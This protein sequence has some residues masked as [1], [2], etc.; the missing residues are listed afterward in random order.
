MAHGAGSWAAALAEFGSASVHVAGQGLHVAAYLW[1]GGHRGAVGVAGRVG[2]GFADHLV[3][4][5]A[6]Q[7]ARYVLGP[8]PVR[9][10]VQGAQTDGAGE[11]GGR[12]VPGQ[13]GRPHLT[14]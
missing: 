1:V 6:V 11:Q 3:L 10:R 8:A 14:V 5:P 9:V 4:D 12:V 2:H 13:L 7:G